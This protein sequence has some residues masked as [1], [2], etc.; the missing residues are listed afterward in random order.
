L[1]RIAE[2]NPKLNAVVTLDAER[3][4]KRA[5]EADEA[6][7]RGQSWGPLHGLPITVK[8]LF[9]AIFTARI[10]PGRYM[11]PLAVFLRSKSSANS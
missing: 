3:A 1:K 6:L 8:D 10:W 5:A 2:V 11:L 7:V 4:R 9:E